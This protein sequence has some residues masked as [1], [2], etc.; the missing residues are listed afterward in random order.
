MIVKSSFGGFGKH[1]YLDH[2]N[3][4]RTVYAHLDKFNV[5]KKSRKLREVN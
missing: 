4:Y 1:I 3:G 5:R 2:G